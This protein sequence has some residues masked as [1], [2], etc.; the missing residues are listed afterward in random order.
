MHGNTALGAFFCYDECMA[1]RDRSFQRITRSLE[2]LTMS[3]IALDLEKDLNMGM[4]PEDI[5]KKYQPRLTARSIM[6]ALAS[7]NEAIATTNIK[8]LTDRTEGK[9]SEKSRLPNPL[10]KLSDAQLEALL[11]TEISDLESDESQIT[12][13]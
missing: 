4:S 2:K 6:L 12:V 11:R 7:E 3:E 13:N 9:A 10:E 5:R 8:D 1:K